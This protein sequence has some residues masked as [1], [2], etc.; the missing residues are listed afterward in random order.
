MKRNYCFFRYGIYPITAFAL[1]QPPPPK[2]RAV[3]PEGQSNQENSV[4]PSNQE[5][6]E[7]RRVVQVLC[8]IGLLDS[9]DA[10]NLIMVF[11]FE[12]CMNRQC[13]T[14][15]TPND[16][17]DGLVEELIEHRFISAVRFKIV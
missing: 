14:T 7:S 4:T 3:S 17:P 5:D 1:S 6:S 12:D 9:F 8:S 15:I 10:F 13:T 11:R 2:T 16:T